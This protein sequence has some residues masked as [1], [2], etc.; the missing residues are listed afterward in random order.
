MQ[1]K[2]NLSKLTFVIAKRDFFSFIYSPVAYIVAFI[3]LVSVGWFF[4]NTFFLR[5]TA[6]LRE[7]FSLLPMFFAFL[8]PAITMK[9]FADEINTGTYE[10]LITLPVKTVE[11]VLGKIVSSFLFLLFIFLPTLFYFI[12]VNLLGDVEIGTAI[13][14]YIGAL[15][16]GLSFVA[17]GVFASSTTKSPIVAW[18]IGVAICFPLVIINQNTVILFPDVISKLLLYLSASYHFERITRGVIDLRDLIYFLSVTFVFGY[19]AF[20]NMKNKIT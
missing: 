19:L 12:T 8:I 2:N 1:E 15:F 6:Q 13:G 18:I 4:F 10:M 5:Q 17:V 11:V 3:F 16:L 20:L 14:G 9:S 7:F